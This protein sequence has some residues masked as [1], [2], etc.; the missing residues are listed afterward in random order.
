MG[1]YRSRPSG[2]RCRVANMVPIAVGIDSMTR[3]NLKSTIK[4]YLVLMLM[5]GRYWKLWQLVALVLI[6]VGLLVFL[7]IVGPNP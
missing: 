3:K 5:G 2:G 4:E 6:A 1:D 7:L